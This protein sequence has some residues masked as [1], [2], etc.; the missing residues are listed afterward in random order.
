M[1]CENFSLTHICTP[2]QKTFLQPH[3]Y[4]RILPSGIIVYSFYK[5]SEIKELLFTKHTDIG[6]HIYTILAKLSFSK[7]ADE[8]HSKEIKR[9]VSIAIDDKPKNS[10]SHTAILN[11]ALKTYNIEPLYTKL[12][13]T[14]DISYSGKSRVYRLENPRNFHLKRF[15]EKEIILVDDIITTGTTLT[16]AINICH[17]AGK[18]VL[19]CLTLSDVNIK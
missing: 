19:F 6:F 5:Y 1:L 2:C 4:K 18:E 12:Y 9:L 3:L 11:K 14:N 15:K 16:Q 17:K 8:F 7:F 13:A 10:Y